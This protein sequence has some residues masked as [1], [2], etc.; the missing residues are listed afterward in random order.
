MTRTGAARPQHTFVTSILTFMVVGM[1]AIVVP[2]VLIVPRL[3]DPVTLSAADLGSVL[4]ATAMVAIGVL[5]L[6]HE[7]AT[8]IGYRRERRLQ[9]RPADD[10]AQ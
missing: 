1:L 7:A 5:W 8:T 2:Q 10:R 3:P 4:T 9:R 6:G